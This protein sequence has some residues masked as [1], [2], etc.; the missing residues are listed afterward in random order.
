MRIE[1]LQS[2]RCVERYFSMGWLSNGGHERN[3]IWHKGSL[4][5][6][7]DGQA[8]ILSNTRRESARYHTL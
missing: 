3:E 2:E 4:G 8:F 6:E 1:K 7:D 5:D